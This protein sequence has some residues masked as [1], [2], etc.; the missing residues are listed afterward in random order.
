M[1]QLKKVEINQPLS[2]S[3]HS[4]PP[5]YRSAKEEPSALHAGE[6]VQKLTFAEDF[7]FEHSDSGMKIMK[8]E[9]PNSRL[10]ASNDRSECCQQFG[11]PS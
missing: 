5:M 6:V 3:Q 7:L 11:F 10:R 8:I 4:L 1:G 9:M 2:R